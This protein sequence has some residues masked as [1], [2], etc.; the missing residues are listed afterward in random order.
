MKF[1]LIIFS[2]ICL[3]LYNINCL[4]NET[5]QNESALKVGLI[6]PLTGKDQEIG[7]ISLEWNWLVGWYK[8]PDDGKPKGIHYTE[9][10]PWLGEEFK[11]V[12]YGD[13]WLEYLKNYN[14][15]ILNRS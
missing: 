4:A 10:G 1:V 15:Q 13:I 3:N 14:V 11:N 9:G 8:E 12:E 7:K 5:T 2:I 6:V